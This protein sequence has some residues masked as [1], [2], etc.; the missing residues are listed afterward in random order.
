MQS[1]Y[2]GGDEYGVG[3]RAVCV[4]AAEIISVSRGETRNSNKY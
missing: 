1:P 2:R 4:R 3:I